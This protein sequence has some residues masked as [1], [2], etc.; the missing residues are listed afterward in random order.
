M[1]I[2]SL[3]YEEYENRTV[4]FHGCFS[5]GLLIGGF[6]VDLALR[7]LPGGALYDVICESAKCLPDAVQL[8]T[9]CSIGNGWM[10]ILKIG[11]FAVTFYDKHTGDGIRVYLDTEK[12]QRWPEIRSWFLKL[13]PKH[14][15]DTRL[16]MAQIKEAGCDILS[17]KPVLIDVARFQKKKG[18]PI[19]ICPQ[20]NEAYPGEHGSIC[21]V[22]AGIL[23]YFSEADVLLPQKMLVA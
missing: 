21:R 2:G 15:Q 19:S 5:P 4:A 18:K 12:L 6:M 3:S 10:K 16:L 22:C 11:R 17:T 9:P 13:V 20:C 23:G 14:E 1:N 8:L 7:S